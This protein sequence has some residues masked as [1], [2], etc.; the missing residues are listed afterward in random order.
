MS[1]NDRLFL[2]SPEDN[3]VR[4]W[5]GSRSRVVVQDARLRWPDSL[6]EADDGSIYVTASR[7]QDMPWFK[8]DA[9]HVLPTKLF[10][11]ERDGTG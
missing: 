1:R 9:P 3:S 6:A 11:L 8:A 5:D 10:R 2:T 7:I 4:M